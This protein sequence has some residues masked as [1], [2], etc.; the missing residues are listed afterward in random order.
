MKGKASESTIKHTK[1][2]VDL[3]NQATRLKIIRMRELTAK[4]GLCKSA[5]YQL[6]RDGGFP[7]P[8]P[9][10][11]GRARGWLESTIDEWI[12]A[13]SDTRSGK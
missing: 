9:I 12:A 7:A 4:V 6:I 10:A 13:Q 3:K 1:E 5:I 8:F 2:L 11:G